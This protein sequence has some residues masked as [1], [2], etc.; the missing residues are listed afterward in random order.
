MHVPAHGAAQ[1]P[2]KEHV[3]APARDIP[4]PA[5]GEAPDRPA[6]PVPGPLA[7]LILAMDRTLGTLAGEGGSR[8]DLHAL[9]NHLS[10]LCVLTE[11]TPRILRAVERVVAAGDRL[12]EAAV[13]VRG[14]DWRTPR[15]IKARAALAT[16]ENALAGARPSRIALRLDRGW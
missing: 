12:G 1:E 9:R 3:L 15:L 7:G 4:A 8:H 16:L 10:D 2:V 14:R 6:P 5:P 13:A 11:E